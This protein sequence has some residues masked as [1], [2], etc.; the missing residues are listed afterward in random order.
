VYLLTQRAVGAKEIAED[1]KL[2]DTTLSLFE[3]IEQ[4]AKP[5]Q[6]MFPWLPSPA[7]IKRF[8]GGTRMYMIFQKLVSTRQTTGRREEDALQYLID[9][10]DDIKM[11]IAVRDSSCHFLE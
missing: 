7:L 3:T 6:V 2:L 10:G 9:Q 1:R 4:S 8:Y 11:I 5:Y